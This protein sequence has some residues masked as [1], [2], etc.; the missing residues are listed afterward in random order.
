MNGRGMAMHLE[1][2]GDQGVPIPRKL[3]AIPR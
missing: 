2:A 3:F 1:E